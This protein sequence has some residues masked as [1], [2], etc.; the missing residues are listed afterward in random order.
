MTTMQPQVSKHAFLF[1]FITVLVDTMGFGI[2][3]PVMPELIMELTGETVSEASLA[4]GWLAASYAI[5]QFL[6]GP[7]IGNLS[8]RFG[9]RPVLLFSLTA[10][11][12][13]YAV[14]GLAPTLSWLFVG[15][16]VAGIA[17][18]S[19]TSANAAVADISPP[20]KRAQNFGLIGA[21]FGIGFILGPAVGGLLGSFGPRAPF[22]AAAALALLNV[23]YGYFMLPETLAP[24]ARR[25]FS[26]SRAN[27]FGTLLQMRKYPAVFGMAGVLFLWQ[28]AHQ[29]LP[30]TWAFY[31]QLKFKWSTSEI[32][33]SLA[34]AGATMIIVQG[35]MTRLI[36]PRL[37]EKRAA[38][39]GICVAVLGYLGYAFSTHSWMMYVC[40]TLAA[41]MG[42]AFPS[43]N[44]LMSRQIPPTAQG[45]LQGGVASLYSLTAILGPLIMTQLFGFFTSP[46]APV[47][48]P[49]AAFAFAALLTV[50]CAVLF[51]RAV[52]GVAFDPIEV[53]DSHVAEDRFGAPEPAIE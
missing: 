47:Y 28:L 38:M 5:A 6:F 50:I 30:T 35:G 31:T 11:G 48:F 53:P 36:I 8:D 52:R 26:W 12:L 22:F 29:V 9:R 4:G 10:F 42:L 3:M 37:G 14:M 1:V 33:M 7:V 44:A 2:I 16:V 21:A 45:E 51:V 13:D 34:F 19:H 41:L 23:I 46:A 15:R 40:I 25:P 27:T 43:M 18:A 24:E 20:E 32:G 49:G 17:G 39:L